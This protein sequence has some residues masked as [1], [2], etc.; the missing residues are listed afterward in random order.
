[1]SAPCPRGSYCP[2][3]T[4]KP[5]ACTWLSYCPQG[6]FS[7]SF[8]GGLVITAGLD[9][10]LLIIGL[11]KRHAA[12]KRK[13]RLAALE[14]QA[15]AEA[16]A[17][18]LANAAA[19][20]PGVL[21]RRWS[22]VSHVT[23]VKERSLW[24]KMH[25]RMEMLRMDLFGRS[26][27]LASRDDGVNRPAGTAENT[28]DEL[29]D[30][31]YTT[32]KRI[33]RTPVAYNNSGA[34][35]L[36]M[37]RDPDPVVGVTRRSSR[38]GPAPGVDNGS[39]SRQSSKRSRTSSISLQENETEQVE[40]DRMVAMWQKGL[41]QSGEI[42][43]EFSFKDLQLTLPSG[44][45]VL[46]NV[47]GK[48][49]AGRM[50]AI[51]GPSGS[52]KTT[53]INLLMGRIKST[54]GEIMV[55]NRPCDPSV[56][57]KVI[58]YVPQED[59]MIR[60]LT[61]REVVLHSGRVRL[62]PTWAEEEVEEHVNNV[63]RMLG[64]LHVQDCVIG[65][66]TRRGLSGGQRR[67]VNLAIELAAAPLTLLLDEPTSGLDATSALLLTQLLARV[68]SIGLT[69]IA[70][71]HQPRPEV[72]DHF[73]DAILLAPN[74]KGVAYAGPVRKMRDYFQSIGFEFRGSLVGNDGT[75]QPDSIFVYDGKND[76]D[77][78]MDILSGKVI[79]DERGKMSAKE[80][81]SAWKKTGADFINGDDPSNSSDTTATDSEMVQRFYNTIG[82]L[83]SNRGAS[84][85]QQLLYCHQR[86]LT[87]QRRTITSFIMECL[88]AFVAGSLMG[89]SARSS[90]ELYQGIFKDNYI[91]LSPVRG[92][93][94]VV[95]GLLVGMAVAMAGAPAGVKVF[96][97]ERTV[98]WR[99]KA[100]G[101]NRAA[102]YL[103][104]TISTFYRFIVSSLH[105]T[106]IYYY[107]AT[108]MVPFATQYII[109]LLSFWGTYGLSAVVSMTVRRE[110]AALLAVVS[111]LF[112]AVF[113]G[114]GP[115]LSQARDYHVD[116]IFDMSFN[117]W[118]AEAQ[119]SAALST[120][121]NIYDV[122]A[123]SSVYGYT[124]NRIPFDFTMML[125]IGL[126]LR[127]I[128][129]FLLIMLDPG[130]SR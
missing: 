109:I 68:T 78:I 69:T 65:D 9:L 94:I 45:R 110:N 3:G 40:L 32:A 48:M 112:V 53:L 6:S 37:D 123:S 86:S 63:L 100:S 102:Y 67:R 42:H 27:S 114:T 111:G 87:Q 118:G 128:A 41:N 58:G 74:G 90:V 25:D 49:K 44:R 52:G 54:S 113:C 21:P 17:R 130:K 60:E 80:L 13:Q 71:L 77:R 81:V 39:L 73:H 36:Q 2:T 33:E 116:W 83:I 99:E 46:R 12:K 29:T 4:T 76:A 108:P 11:I 82:Q 72:L 10:L 70:I 30:N 38:N 79:G 120:Y 122:E 92:D 22:V 85:L 115:T 91:V 88:V 59:I 34:E 31:E 103:G 125:V 107:L 28:D 35:T 89:L 50:T 62:P 55:N 16:E 66:E 126:A 47:S 104:K 1:M 121:K 18:A 61:V 5:I 129:F 75:Q 23:T 56:F 105:F 20:V 93:R 64:L 8:Y 101:H 106:S 7:Q 96:A 119:Y 95:Y 117:R 98:F 51:M 127:I 43:M 14:A 84:F 19:A 97:E 124:L 57:Q 24:T 15:K 26:S